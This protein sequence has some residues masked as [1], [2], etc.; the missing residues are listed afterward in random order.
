MGNT[1]IIAVNRFRME[2]IKGVSFHRKNKKAS[3][4][5]LFGF[6]TE[7]GLEP[8]SRSAGRTATRS[9]VPVKC[10]LNNTLCD[11]AV[12]LLLN[13]PLPFHGFFFRWERLRIH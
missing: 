7:E 13:P 9:G 11:S 1:G 3:V 4:M 5:R 12:F 2:N 10:S 6:A 8:P